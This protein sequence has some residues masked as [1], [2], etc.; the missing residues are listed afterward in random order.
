MAG[1]VTRRTQYLVIRREGFQTIKVKVPV[2]LRQDQMDLDPLVDP[3]PT[4]DDIVLIEDSALIPSEDRDL[5]T[6]YEWFA[7]TAPWEAN[8]LS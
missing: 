5:I 8:E 1:E 2:V 7:I 6:E 3:I 4:N